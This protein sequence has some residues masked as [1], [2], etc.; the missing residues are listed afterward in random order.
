MPAAAADHRVNRPAL[1]PLH[2]TFTYELRCSEPWSSGTSYFFFEQ[3]R[4]KKSSKRTFL[5]SRGE[6]HA[7][8]PVEQPPRPAATLHFNPARLS[9]KAISTH[10]TP[11]VS[12][13]H[14]NAEFCPALSTPL[15]LTPTTTH[16]L[17]IQHSHC[18]SPH[19]ITPALRP[20]HDEDF[21][22]QHRPQPNGQRLRR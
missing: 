18:T 15:S 5:R 21:S 16:L 20:R 8:D 2:G 11:K 10:R 3:I 9:R 6:A 17:T 19:Q 12:H 22:T 13:F 14:P 1:L 7:V 4:R